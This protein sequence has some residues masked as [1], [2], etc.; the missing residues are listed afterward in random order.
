MEQTTHKKY[1]IGHIIGFLLSLIMT[2][3]AMGVALHAPLSKSIIMTIIGTL[4]FLQA[5]MQLFMFMHVNESENKTIQV[6]NIMYALMIALV[7]VVGS[8]WVMHG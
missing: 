2:F 1:P 6:I 4:A 3:V 7:I 8:I 5:G